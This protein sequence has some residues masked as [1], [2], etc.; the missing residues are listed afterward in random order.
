MNTLKSNTH[1]YVSYHID[2]KVTTEENQ[3]LPLEE[4]AMSK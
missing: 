3:A 2:C 4:N 1:P